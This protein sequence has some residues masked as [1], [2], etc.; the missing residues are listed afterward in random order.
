MTDPIL[1]IDSP[2]ICHMVKHRMGSF[3]YEEKGVGVIYGFLKQIFTLSKKFQTTKF[4]FIWDSKKSYR[5]DLL[6]EYKEDRK[7][8]IRN[9]PEIDQLNRLAYPQFTKLR[10]YVLPKLGFKNNFIQTGLEADDLIA[11]AVTNDNIPKVIISSD[12]DLYQLLAPDV[13]M[14]SPKT[15]KIYTLKHFEKEFGVEPSDWAKIKQIAGC[16]GDSVPGIKGVGE[17]TALKFFTGS[18][19]AKTTAYKAITSPEGKE[20]ISRN[21]KL[22]KLPFEGTKSLTFNWNEILYTADFIGILEK[23]GFK[24]ILQQS[25]LDTWIRQ[26]SMV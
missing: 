9:K 22:V 3:T 2:A 19:N 13:V 26:F 8:A 14:C 23:Y 15:K 5:K 25:V 17:K 1:L 20:I 7:A 11:I 18:L 24:S 10:C 6:P 21:E 4:V 16:R 12:N